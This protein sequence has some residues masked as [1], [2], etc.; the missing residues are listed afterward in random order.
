MYKILIYTS[1]IVITS[2]CSM[3][4]GPSWSWSYGSWTYNYLCN[5][6]LLPLTLWVR[7]PIMA[8][9]TKMYLIQHYV[10]KFVSDLRQ[11]VGFSQGTPVSH[12]NKTDH[13]D[14]NEILLKVALDTINLKTTK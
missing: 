9:C 11:V 12:T 3:F 7:I 1:H 8:R 5:Q 10:I 4:Y 14:I 13:H 6:C 2:F